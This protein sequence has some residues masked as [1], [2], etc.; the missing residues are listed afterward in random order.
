MSRFR[1]YAKRIPTF[2]RDRP[3]LFVKH[4]M[5]RYGKINNDMIE[6]KEGSKFHVQSETSSDIYVCDMGIPRCSC[7]DFKKYNWPCKH[8]LAVMLH[9]EAYGWDF[10]PVSYTTQPCFTI[11]MDVG[12]K[13]I[14][15]KEQNTEQP[16]PSSL[17]EHS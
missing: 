8:L 1:Q 12:E 7:L 9:Y 2:M 10:L 17:P 6:K 11:D 3:Q 5:D 4:C 15:G 14:C 16:A 13:K